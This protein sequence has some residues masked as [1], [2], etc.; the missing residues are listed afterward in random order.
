M[1]LLTL[2][3]VFTLCASALLTGCDQKMEQPIMQI[4][5]PPQ[6]ASEKAQAAMER[7]NER[8]ATAYQTAEETGDFSTIFMA[9]EDIFKEELGFRKGLWVDLVDIYRQENRENAELLEGFENL[10]EAFVKKL[11]EGTLEVFYFEYISS[12]DG[13]IIEYLRLSFEFPEK[14]EE[15]RL[16]LFK[17]SVRDAEIAI[18]FP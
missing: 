11:K 7:V 3:I 6:S 16:A 14:S 4:I 10:Q 12:F 1:K 13:I 8:R 9:S 18:I 15:E 5:T 2:L 17:E